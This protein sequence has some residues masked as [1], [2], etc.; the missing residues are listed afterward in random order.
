MVT[1]NGLD[2]LEA[3]PELS[4][5]FTITLKVSVDPEETLH[6]WKTLIV[7]PWL[8]KQVVEA[9]PSPQSMVYLIWFPSGSID[10]VV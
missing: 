6:L 4:V 5:A 2:Q 9:V 1:G 10:L 3:N 7:K 8:T